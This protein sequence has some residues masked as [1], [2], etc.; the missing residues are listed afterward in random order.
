VM[1]KPVK[2]SDPASP[3]SS[4]SSPIVQNNSL[5]IR[6]PAKINWF[7]H[8]LQKRKDGYHDIV[9]LM[10]CVSLYDELVFDHADSIAVESDMDIPVSD[11]LVYKAASLLKKIV[12]YSKGARIFVKKQIPVSAGLG[13]GSSDAAYTL[14]G[15]NILWGLGL[16][17]EELCSIGVR[18]GSDVPFFFHAPAALVKGKGESVNTLKID[19]SCRLLLVNPNVNVSTAWAYGAFDQ[20]PGHTLTK[21]PLDIKLFCQALHRQDF[22]S[23][24]D[25]LSNDFEE[26]VMGEYPAISEIK[27]KLVT[28]GAEA[29]LMSGSG[30]TVFGVF[31][32]REKAEKALAAMK[33]H[34]CRIVKTLI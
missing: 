32:S 17:R 2:R 15:L 11:N 8:I 19:P 4:V 6:A 22:L 7:L 13:G 23:L 18:I 27:H 26:I 34:W 31:K 5:S 14:T 25:M 16:Q 9:S 28:M 20:L 33:P 1:V 10:Q 12:S 29:S 21:K 3:R 30:P 24:A